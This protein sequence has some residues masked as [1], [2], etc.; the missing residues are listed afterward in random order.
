MSIGPLQR[1]TLPRQAGSRRASATAAWVKT[2]PV[3][4]G[5]YHCWD[6]KIVRYP[7][8]PARVAALDGMGRWFVV[9]II[10]GTC[11]LLLLLLIAG[12]A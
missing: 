5:D 3:V 10:V 2:W 7:T 8:I 1:S 9:L 11:M 12:L 6:I 4:F